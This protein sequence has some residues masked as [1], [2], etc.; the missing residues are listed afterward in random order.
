M[1]TVAIRASDSPNHKVCEETPRIVPCFTGVPKT[2]GKCLS[3]QRN[4][5]VALTSILIMS[6]GAPDARQ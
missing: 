1:N 4:F 3:V 5:V 2:V 6:R